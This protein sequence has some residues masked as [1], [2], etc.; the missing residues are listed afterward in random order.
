MSIEFEGIINPQE[1]S[2]P[3]GLFGSYNKIALPEQCV[4]KIQQM[5]LSSNNYMTS[6]LRQSFQMLTK[7][8]PVQPAFSVRK[9]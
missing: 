7:D 2:P 6:S 3:A 8:V 1:S 4:N 9:Q 5:Y